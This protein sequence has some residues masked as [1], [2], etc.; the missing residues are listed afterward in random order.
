MAH[1][2]HS[3]KWRHIRDEAEAAYRNYQ[4]SRVADVADDSEGPYDYS[5]EYGAVKFYVLDTRSQRL[6]T[7]GEHARVFAPHQ[8]ERFSGWLNANAYAPLL[9]VVLSVPPFFMP[10]WASRIARHVPG[11]F[12]EDAHDR[13][14]HPQYHQ[15]RVRLLELIRDH[16]IR[17]PRQKVVLVCG[18]VHVGYVTRCEWRTEPPT[19]LYQFVSSAVTHVLPSVDWHMARHIPRTQFALFGVGDHWARVHLIGS[20]LARILHQPVG[21]LNVGIIEAQLSKDSAELNFRL[22]GE[23]EG[24]PDEPKNLFESGFE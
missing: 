20:R 21:G 17:Q 2:H 6:S 1:E 11:A 16:Q 4:H 12:K 5:Y 3:D 15:D 9:F 8:L 13:W 19:A 10:G 14:M 24:T 23:D 18:D 7:D 22:I